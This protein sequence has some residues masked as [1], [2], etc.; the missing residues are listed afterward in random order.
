MNY[1]VTRKEVATGRIFENICT[2]EQVD[3][4][5]KYPISLY[6]LESIEPI[7]ENSEVTD[8]PQTYTYYCRLRPPF[9]GCQP[10]NGLIE[11]NCNEIEHNNRTYWGTVTYNRTLTDAELYSYDL[12]K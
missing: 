2:K 6:S 9:I 3:N 8:E 4:I 5:T 11:T 7:T 12:D 1:K 10:R